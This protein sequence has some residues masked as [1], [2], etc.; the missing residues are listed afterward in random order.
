MV[1]MRK[2]LIERRLPGVGKQTPGDLT[3]AAA[4]SNQVLRNLGTGVQWLNSYVTD[5]A[6]FCVYLAENEDLIRRHAVESGFPADK[7]NSVR[8]VLD[9]ASE[10]A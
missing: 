9:P 8:A 6:I 2:Y 7:I 1:M 5:D 10:A 3:A 4:K